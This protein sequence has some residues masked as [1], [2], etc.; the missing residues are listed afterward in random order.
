MASITMSHSGCTIWALRS[1]GLHRLSGQQWWIHYDDAPPLSAIAAGGNGDDLWALQEDRTLLRLTRDGV[2]TV[3]AVG[4]AVW[5]FSVGADGTVCALMEYTEGGDDSLLFPFRLGPNFWEYWGGPAAVSISV[6]NADEVWLVG[7]SGNVIR[8]NT[9]RGWLPIGDFTNAIWISAADDGTVL[10][11]ATDGIYRLDRENMQ[12][13]LFAALPPSSPDSQP[14]KVECG[15]RDRVYASDMV[16]LWIRQSQSW[17]PLPVQGMPFWRYSVAPDGCVVGLAPTGIARMTSFGWELLD[18]I[19]GCPCARSVDDIWASAFLGRSNLEHLPGLTW[20][21][22]EVTPVTTI[23]VGADDEMWGLRMD[24][25]V[26]DLY[27]RNGDDGTWTLMKP[28]VRAVAV[29]SARHVAML[30]PQRL[31]RVFDPD[32]RQWGEPLPPPGGLEEFRYVGIGSDGTIA[33][34]TGDKVRV[35]DAAAKAWSVLVRNSVYQLQVIDEDHLCAWGSSGVWTTGG[36]FQA[37][38]LSETTAP[39]IDH[40]AVVREFAARCQARRNAS[41]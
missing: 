8:T 30:D 32:T 10:V 33:A 1:S 21:T 20:Q 11:T 35:W 3:Q 36:V 29:G 41:A 34:A 26:G 5:E 13:E 4:N 38:P 14:L 9:T 15:S 2:A 28:T 27:R 16:G 39:K 12:F 40:A 25:D 31:V 24:G 22:L 37:P 17:A 18:G 23:S 7:S 6:V 19:V